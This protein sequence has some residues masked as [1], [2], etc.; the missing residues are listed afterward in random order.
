MSKPPHSSSS[1]EHQQQPS[2][3]VRHDRLSQQHQQSILGVAS[4]Q[5]SVPP[6]SATTYPSNLA[7]AGGIAHNVTT[8]A[9][10]APRIGMPMNSNL[11]TNSNNSSMVSGISHYPHNNSGV[12][13][14]AAAP[15]RPNPSQL[16]HTT[17]PNQRHHVH[18][19]HPNSNA[20]NNSIS[21]VH[22]PQHHAQQHHVQQHHAQQHHAQQ[23][24]HANAQRAPQ[25]QQPNPSAAPGW[26]TVPNPLLAT[27]AKSLTSI[28]SAS[29]V[30]SSRSS[31]NKP[32]VVLSPE[33]RQ[34]LAKAIWSSIRSPTGDVDPEA[35]EEAVNAGLPRHAIL[36]A[37]RV[38]REREAMKRKANTAV[39]AMPTNGEVGPVT[40][41]NG[42]KNSQ[43]KQQ[44]RIA[45]SA[46]VLSA[47]QITSK[48]PV[49]P[50]A[51]SATIMQQQKIDERNH[52]KRVL[53]GVFHVQ[54]GR[55]LG[56]QNSIS[57]CLRALPQPIILPQNATQSFVSL[58]LNQLK[59]I[60]E[61]ER[62]AHSATK[63]SNAETKKRIKMEPKR[64]SKALD[65][66]MKKGRQSTQESL[67]KKLKDVNKSIV[68]HASD[69]FKYH[70]SIKQEASKLAKAVRDRKSKESTTERKQA[71]QAERARIAALKANDMDAYKSLL[72]NTKN[73]RLQYLWKKTDECLEH[74]SSSLRERNSEKEVTEEQPTSYYASAHLQEEE[75][76]QPSILIGGELK[77][78]QLAGLQWLVSLYNNK[79]NGILADEMGL[80]KTIQA[81]SLVAYLMEFKENLGP[82]L[83]IVPLSTLSNWV[84][85]FAKWC[86]AA[87]VIV[88][89]GTPSQRRDLY[90]NEVR[91]G[92]FNVLLTTYEYIIKDKGSLKKVIWQYAI[93]DEGHRMKNA[94]SKFAVTLGTVYTTKNR[95]L[96]T[97]TP[98][99]N[100]LPE[101]WALLNFLLPAIFNSVESFDEWFNRP[102]STFS[103]S[104]NQ[105]EN[106][107][108]QMLSNEERMLIIHRL[109]ELLRP[110]MLRRVKSE[111]LDQ[112][113][114]KVEKVLRCDLSSWQKELYKQISRKATIDNKLDSFVE[115]PAN[116]TRGLNNVVMQLRK[117]CNHPYLFSTQGYILNDDLIR[118]SGKFQLL[119]EMLPK[120]KAAGHRILMFT[121]MTAVMTIL[122]DYFRYRNYTSL[123]LDG[124]TPADERERRMYKFNAPDS[125]YFIFLLSTRAGGLGLNLATADVVIIFDSDWNPMMDLQAQDRAHR[126]GQR[127]DVSVF[128]LI[129]YSPVEEKIL[130]RAN[131]KLNMSE[132]V[133]EAGKFTQDSVEND[134]S[135]ERRKMMEV[136]LTDFDSNVNKNQER[137]DDL[138]QD[139]GDG[140]GDLDDE[141]DDKDSTNSSIDLNELLSNN[142]QDFQVYS[143]L[144]EKNKEEP[145]TA[146]YTDSGDVP[147][148][149]KYPSGS[150]ETSLKPKFD[151]TVGR[152]RTTVTY[153]DGLTEKQFLRLMEKQADK[154]ELSSRK[155]KI[156]RISSKAERES[157]SRVVGGAASDDTGAMTEWTFRKLTSICK[158][159]IALK[160]PAT[161][162]KLSEI[163]I[164]KPDANAYP[165]YYKII[166]RPIAINDILRKCRGQLYATLSEFWDDW[167]V[168]FANAKAYNGAGSWVAN[169]AEELQRELERVMK[170][171]GF[172]E[173]PPPPKRKPL[174]IKLSLKAVKADSGTEEATKQRSKKRRKS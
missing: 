63:L 91:N 72:E 111:V 116:L 152:K 18:H 51:R 167:K 87:R 78:Y 161:K 132:L 142:E 39:R 104:S 165:D 61:R 146:L 136:L 77:E 37:A 134:N 102:F 40:A 43:P 20:G 122:E 159:V 174:R 110:F 157:E 45:S 21:S 108:D 121:Q 93:V 139:P 60:Q 54:K 68:A 33:A 141:E 50:V 90:K 137:Q 92:Q 26:N 42:T 148:W 153:D 64:V 38:A 74:I 34:A 89:K 168:L 112:L 119:D 76:R 130:A 155:R 145:R 14:N 166:E 69:F 58:P 6:P 82:Y 56:L 125:P 35:M 150:K 80:G 173:P 124:S 109:H 160:D 44:V 67:L 75:V 101:L 113:P 120:L 171:N 79:L 25:R 9:P 88:Y 94:Q 172:E 28:Q 123:R 164:D 149:I 30:Q 144:D 4:A 85:E 46:P 127:S 97:G 15:S 53:S 48:S 5:R 100:S 1:S 106:E 118:S 13:R 65:R 107:T 126:I 55:Y 19:H 162:R 147:D 62:N 154:D 32:K 117:V 24:S 7:R 49:A 169:D 115:Q 36:N 22:Q 73:D 70:R 140:D 59:A 29:A 151:P 138:K 12:P 131:E 57:S 128:R 133:V 2:L 23:H 105:Q 95:I 66:S 103:G 156:S 170:K 84:N 16:H 143:S 163:F 41:L 27:K 52:W 10:S 158:A 71:D 114:E 96:L 47:K 86:P 81:I 8:T 83:V 135:M 31:V 17:V 99:Q 98:L 129:T 11:P 3:A